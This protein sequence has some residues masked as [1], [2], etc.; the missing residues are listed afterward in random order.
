MVALND[1]TIFMYGHRPGPREHLSGEAMTTC[2]NVWPQAHK[3]TL[4][5]EPMPSFHTDPDRWYHEP[6]YCCCSKKKPGYCCKEPKKS[7]NRMVVRETV[8]SRLN[9]AFYSHHHKHDVQTRHRACSTS[10]TP[11]KKDAYS[12]LHCMSQP[13]THAHTNKAQH[14]TTTS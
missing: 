14:I 7:P 12:I 2:R 11:I 1:L 3:S 9:A 8:A 10:V 6:G 5:G 13:D 4:S